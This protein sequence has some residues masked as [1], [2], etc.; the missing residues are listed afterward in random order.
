MA[1]F[2]STS[3]ARRRA[4]PVR[5]LFLFFLNNG[6]HVVGLDVQCLQSVILSCHLRR[7]PAI[8]PIVRLACDSA[9][10]TIVQDSVPHR[11]RPS[12]TDAFGRSPFSCCNTHASK[13]SK[14]LLLHHLTELSV[15]G[16][17]RLLGQFTVKA[18]Y[19]VFQWDVPMNLPTHIDQDDLIRQLVGSLISISICHIDHHTRD[20]VWVRPLGLA[21]VTQ[22]SRLTAGRRPHDMA[23]SCFHSNRAYV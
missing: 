12:H 18:G 7:H 8:H 10:P 20:F 3:H 15:E 16:I 11:G 6:R 19:Q 22:N 4:L 14:S 23:C 2:A 1:P 9:L 17:G 13:M 21:L 5:T